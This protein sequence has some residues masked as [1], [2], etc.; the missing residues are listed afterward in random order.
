MGAAFAMF[1]MILSGLTI[2]S[3]YFIFPARTQ[4][5]IKQFINNL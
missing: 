2:M 4:E 3:I 5:E 1:Y